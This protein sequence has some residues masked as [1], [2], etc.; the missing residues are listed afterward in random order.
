MSS[1]KTE[2]EGTFLDLL[3]S[4]VLAKIATHI[5]YERPLY[6]I[7]LYPSNN[8]YKYPHSFLFTTKEDAEVFM[9]HLKNFK[10]KLNLT[11]LKLAEVVYERKIATSPQKALEILTSQEKTETTP[12]NLDELAWTLKNTE[13]DPCWQEIKSAFSK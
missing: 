3:P 6:E 7:C 9:S 11:G 12:K 2:L 5:L 13:M 1:E 4:D 8:L 10:I